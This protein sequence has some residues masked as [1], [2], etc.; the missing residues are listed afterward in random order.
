MYFPLY[1]PQQ[2]FFSGFT[3]LHTIKLHRSSIWQ[4]R[5]PFQALG[6]LTLIVYSVGFSVCRSVRL[7]VCLSVCLGLTLLTACNSEESGGGLVIW[8]SRLLNNYNLDF[9]FYIK[10]MVQ[11]LRVWLYTLSICPSA[12]KQLREMGSTWISPS[13]TG[14]SKVRETFCSDTPPAFTATQV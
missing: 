4:N 11:S 8:L 10:K 12:H 1:K 6:L 13:V 14:W 2:F 9:N 7:S 3:Q 5:S